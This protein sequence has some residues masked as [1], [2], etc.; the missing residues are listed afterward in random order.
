ME[1]V[2]G[3]AEAVRASLHSKTKR[4]NKWLG[5][6]AE[7][8][9]MRVRS[10]FCFGWELRECLLLAKVLAFAYNNSGKRPFSNKGGVRSG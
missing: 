2:R 3:A 7:K 5:N 8:K 9:R 6:I 1:I 4:K 10:L